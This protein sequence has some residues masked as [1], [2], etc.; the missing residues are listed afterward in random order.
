MAPVTRS[1]LFDPQDQ[2]RFCYKT[3]WDY[4]NL[5]MIGG[6]FTDTLGQTKAD[7]TY[8]V[9]SLSLTSQPDSLY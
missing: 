1:L 3:L 5:R 6:T 4:M 9:A 2:Y 7:K 8:G